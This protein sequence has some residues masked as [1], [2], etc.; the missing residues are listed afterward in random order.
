MPG[1]IEIVEKS[2]TIVIQI[3]KSIIQFF[4]NGTKIDE[5]P[6]QFGHKKHENTGYG[7]RLD[8]KRNGWG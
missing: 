5:F 6:K 4:K 8:E 2:I 3:S 1:N 7:D